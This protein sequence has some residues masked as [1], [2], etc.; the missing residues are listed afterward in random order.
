MVRV[1]N[2]HSGKRRYNSFYFK[3]TRLFSPLYVN[4]TDMLTSLTSKKQFYQ[5]LEHWMT[6]EKTESVPNI[7]KQQ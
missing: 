6:H 5:E 1:L 7:S 2:T 4:K 3:R